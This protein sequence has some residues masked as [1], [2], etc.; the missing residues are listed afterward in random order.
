MGDPKLVTGIPELGIAPLDPMMVDKL[1]FTFFNLTTSS[2][3]SIIKGFGDYQI[4]K[5]VPDTPKGLISCAY[6]FKLLA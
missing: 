1:E 4:E 5:C 6:I 3:D 2:R